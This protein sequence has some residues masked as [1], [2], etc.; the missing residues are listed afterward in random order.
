MAQV[1][2]HRIDPTT[3]EI[4]LINP[5]LAVEA[6]YSPVS[7]MLP[8]ALSGR[9]QVRYKDNGIFRSAR[10]LET[11]YE[12]DA[13]HQLAK[14][15]SAQ[16]QSALVESVLEMVDGNVLDLAA[17]ANAHDIT[18]TKVISGVFS[19]ISTA[20][21]TTADAV[22]LP[23]YGNNLVKRIKNPNAFAILVFP[24]DNTGYIQD[25]AIA[26]A[27]SIPAGATVSFYT[28]RNGATTKR[29]FVLV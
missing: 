6:A 21:Q 5:D 25:G 13:L 7:S 10:V 29:W 27:Y 14:A 8:N 26:A 12:V 23:A 24:N 28:K 22:R 2:L 15:I 9:A 17:A 3:G 16:G 11:H 20:T 1:T 19:N 4:K 18:S